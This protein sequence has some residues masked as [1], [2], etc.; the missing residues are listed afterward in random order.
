MSHHASP[1]SVSASVSN[2]RQWLEEACALFEAGDRTRSIEL[3]QKAA[4]EGNPQAQVNLANIYDDGDGVPRDFDKA[5]Y[6]YKR[7]IR[8]GMPEAAYNLG[9]SYMARGD[10]RWAIH[11][12]KVARAMGDIDAAELLRRTPS[13]HHE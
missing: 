11:W 6:W 8:N 2:P 13:E 10:K 5:R 3:F 9:V 1:E 4:S 7:A 12:L